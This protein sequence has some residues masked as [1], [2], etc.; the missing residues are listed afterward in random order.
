MTTT[1]ARNA[2][3]GL[4]GLFSRFRWGQVCRDALRRSEALSDDYTSRHGIPQGDATAPDLDDRASLGLETGGGYSLAGRLLQ[5]EALQ[6]SATPLSALWGLL[7]PLVLAVTALLSLFAPVWVA[8]LPGALWLVLGLASSGFTLGLV[9]GGVAWALILSA[10][11]LIPVQFGQTAGLVR[12]TLGVSLTFLSL[13]LVPLSAWLDRV[14][15]DGELTEDAYAGAIILSNTRQSEARRA[16]GERAKRDASP[17][18]RL[19]TSQGFAW[20]R[21]DVMAPDPSQVMGLTANDLS[22]GLLVLGAPGTGKTSGVLRPVLHQWVE[23]D[24]GGGLVSDGKGQ[25][26][27]EMADAGLVELLSPANAVVPLI[28]GLNAEEVTGVLLAG[29]KK[30]GGDSDWQS[31]AE[32]MLRHAALLVELAS[33]VGKARWTLSAI[34]RATSDADH[35][36]KLLAVLEEHEDDIEDLGLLATVRGYWL[37][38]YPQV[39]QASGYVASVFGIVSAWLSPLTGHRDL[40]A[41]TQADEGAD[42]TAV[43]EGARYGIGIDAAI[44]GEMAT[45]AVV[46]FIKQRIYNAATIRGDGWADQQGQRAALIMMDE[47]D[48]LL[49]DRDAAIVPRGRSLGLRF[50]VGVQTVEQVEAEFGGMTGS[51]KAHGLLGQFRS[52]VALASTE[53]TAELVSQRAGYGHLLEPVAITSVPDFR[54]TVLQRLSASPMNDPEHPSRGPLLRSAAGKVVGRT[55]GQMFDHNTDSGE[56]LTLSDEPKPWFSVADVQ[57][58]TSTPGVGVAILNRAGAPRRDAIALEPMF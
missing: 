24:C 43:L 2:R 20:E 19:G 40:R 23:H 14:A 45:A 16:Q 13:F 56:R 10:P 3:S 28:A 29:S 39:S 6:G 1:T 30:D 33:E 50:V 48:A 36:A 53:R 27:R 21:G 25:L 47:A 22:T 51:P 38:E 7:V 32:R 4:Q 49:D 58:L 5:S 41:W 42:P 9:A 34:E 17:L 11:S 52:V 57:T 55:L 31:A 8:A 54:Y 35:R 46:G 37:G 15:R 18:I 26:P 12:Y 44:H